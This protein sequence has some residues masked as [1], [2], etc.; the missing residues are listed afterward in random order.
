MGDSACLMQPFSYTAGIPNE[1]KEG[2]PVAVLGQSISFGRFMSDQS[3]A[4]EKWSTFSHKK[5]VEEAQR[6]ARPGSVAQKKAFFEAHYKTLA[7]RKALLEQ[8]KANEGM[9]QDIGTEVSE[10]MNLSSQMA[11]LG[12]EETGSIYDGKENNNSDFV[13]FESSIVEGGDSVGEHNVLLEINLKNEAE[14]KDL[15]L[16]EA[17]HVENLEKKVNQSRK[18]EEVMELEL[19]EETQ[20][21]KPLL[22]MSSYGRRT[23]VP[24]S[25]AIRPNKGNNVTPMSNKSAMEIS[26]RKRSTPKSSHKF[27]NSTPAKEIS[28]LT[29]TII[30]KIGGSRIASNSKPSKEFPTPLRT[31]NMASTSGRPKQ[32][33]ATP[34]LENRSARMPFNSSASV[35]KT[36][37]GKWNLLPTEKKSKYPAIFAPF[38]L[39][40]EERAARRKQRLEE[41]FNAS[42]EQKVEQQTTLKKKAETELKKLRQG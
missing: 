39:R 40:T 33:F 41:K 22:K 14:I 8:A 30:R 31:S 16:S 1:S 37:R 28:R 12:H 18:L 34:W 9:V 42:Q 13:E 35:S 6:Y 11:A 17:T 3:L 38:S 20:I 23:K 15:E 10:I 21:G 27:I 7:A 2:N 4:W 29:S 24:S 32:S 26:D 5:Y 36:S 25:P 19:S